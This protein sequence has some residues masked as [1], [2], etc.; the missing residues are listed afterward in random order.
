M[1]AP[2]RS[3][4]Q[5]EG[6]PTSP[7]DAYRSVWRHLVE[8]DFRQ[9]HAVVGNVRT[10]YIE[11]GIPGKPVIVMLHGTGGHWETFC[12]NI[13]ALAP[14]Y[15]C[16]AIDMIGCGFTD[17]P[18]RPY[19]IADYVDHVLDFLD[20]AG[21][22]SA[23]FI[24]AS[25]GS[26]V[27]CRLSL[28]APD[29]VNGLI[30]NA[31]SGLL[32]LSASSRAIASADRT[33]AR[34]DPSW[35]NAKTVLAHLFFDE[36]SIVDDIIAVRQLVAA[37]AILDDNGTPRTLTLLD[38]EVRARNLLSK[39]EWAAIPVPTLIIAHVDAPDDFLTTAREIEQ[40]IPN[41]RVAEI[42]QARHWP[43]FEQPEAFNA[44]ARDFLADI[45]SAEAADV[46]ASA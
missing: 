7:K 45:T 9:G 11:A 39:E 6:D 4:V 26:W 12:A 15:H 10:R 33:R 27:S 44:A 46:N 14:D 37:E 22:Q 13:P 32:Q 23:V 38:T 19:E 40:L 3:D 29:R 35:E 21:I 5:P 42:H 17:R 28:V 24:G 18:N 43:H 2:R 16:F 1:T 34:T 41:A 25:L 30:L 20:V 31:P 36:S 8:T